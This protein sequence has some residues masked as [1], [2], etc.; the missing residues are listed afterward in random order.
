MR[1]R[2]A[3]AIAVILAVTLAVTAGSALAHTEVKSTS[4]DKGKTART[5][6][7]KVTVTFTEPIRRGTLRVAGP[8][9]KVSI[10]SGHRDRKNVS[11]L[12]V[13]LK[14]GLHAGRYKAE[15]TVVAADGDPQHGSFSFK[16]KK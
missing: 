6:I 1:I 2:Q 4:P 16:L 8:G 5:S 7:R 3:S 12:R 15:W 10:G 14:T 9:G 13:S 11:R